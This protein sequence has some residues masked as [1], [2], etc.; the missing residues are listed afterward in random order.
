MHPEDKTSE[1]QNLHPRNLHRERYNFRQLIKSNPAL[2]PFVSVNQFRDESI[3]FTNPAAVKELNRALLK[4]FY[5][6][7]SWDIPEGY[8]CPPIP[9]RADYIH[10]LAD[11][12]AEGNNGV[13]PN[14]NNVKILDIG[15]GANMVYPLIGSSAY[16]WKFV[17]SEV[18]LVALSSAKNLVILNK[19]KSKIEIRRQGSKNSIF[20]GIIEGGEVFDASMCNP[21]FHSSALEAK[22]ATATK[23]RKLGVSPNKKTPLNFGGQKTELWYPGGEAAFI[24][25]MIDESAVIP[26]NCKWF[27]TLVSKKETLPAAQ[28]ALTKVRATDVRAIN[29]AQGQKVS[30]I[31]AWRF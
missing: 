6:I 9:G 20:G 1:K 25:R 14:G 3:D 27:T 10:Y 13:I 5:N 16:N 30:R 22:E 8:L 15:T 11:L 28:K 2:K 19:L 26:E 29:M 18:D 21:P 31:L 24:T 17:A 7:N 23:W 4:H 12:L